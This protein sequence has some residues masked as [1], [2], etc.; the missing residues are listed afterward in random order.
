MTTVVQNS[1]EIARP[2][3]RE[4][5][6]WLLMAGPAIVVVAGLGTAYIAWA[7]DDGVIAD[8]Y[9]KQGLLINRQLGRIAL[10]EALH[11]G[12]IARITEDGEARV[13]LTGLAIDASAPTTLR[14][15]L[16]HPTRSGQDRMATL[17]RNADGG[18]SGRIK[19]PSMGRWHV[20]VETDAW[21]LP[22]VLASGMQREVRLGAA[23]AAE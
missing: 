15:K 22:T 21:E 16:V 11:L 20:T 17:M 7:T 18:Y 2:W 12:A 14:L 3:Y 8:D 9:Y 10:G 5:W 13:E 23:R 4:R 1:T 6:P 19:P